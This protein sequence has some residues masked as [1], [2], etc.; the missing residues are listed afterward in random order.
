MNWT[1]NSV[2]EEFSVT[3]SDGKPNA[4]IKEI[5]PDCIFIKQSIEM[6]KYT[7]P[8]PLYW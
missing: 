5:P 7:W 1:K 6:N 3:A 8:T 4:M 2:V